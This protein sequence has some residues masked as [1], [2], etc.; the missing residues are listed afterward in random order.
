MDGLLKVIHAA[1]GRIHSHFQQ[2]VTATG[3]LSSVDPNLQNIPVRTELG[4]ELRRMFIAEDAQHVLIDADYSQIELRV[5]AHIAQD[6]AMLDAFR[7]GQDIHAAT[8]AKVYGVPIDEVTAQMRSSC[9]AVNFW[10]CIWHFR[11]C[12]CRGYRRHAK[13]GR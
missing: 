12:A 4:R 8:A 6:E 5:L 10:H 7:N 3:R 2:T 11:F 9:K 1:D 13:T